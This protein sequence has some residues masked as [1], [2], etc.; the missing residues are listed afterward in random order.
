MEVEQFTDFDLENRAL[1]QVLDADNRNR[2]HAG[3]CF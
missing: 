1:G 2:E 3:I